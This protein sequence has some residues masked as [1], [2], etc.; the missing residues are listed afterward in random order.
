MPRLVWILI[1]VWGCWTGTEP[2]PLT[3]P[4]HPVTPATPPAPE[5]ALDTPL[6]FKSGA[7]GRVGDVTFTL[8]MLPKLIVGGPN[9]E[10]EQVQLEVS[11][12]K[13]HSV[14][15]VDTRNKRAE[16]NG[17]VFELG[18]ADVYQDDI[19]LTIRHTPR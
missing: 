4:P 8:K 18:Y 2:S 16:W 3:T 19:E 7:T 15:Q 5:I 1:V 9:P 14:L 17:V 6:H 13:L 11:R 10:I 12:G